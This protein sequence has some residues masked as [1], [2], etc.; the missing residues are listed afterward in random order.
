MSL[1]FAN[2]GPALM[3]EEEFVQRPRLGCMLGLT[4][5]AAFSAALAFGA[6]KGGEFSPWTFL[7]W[8]GAPD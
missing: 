1:R 2:T 8:L 7:L 5:L 4:G 3:Q 6:R